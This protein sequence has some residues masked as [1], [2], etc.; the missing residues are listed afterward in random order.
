[1][2]IE[3]SKQFNNLIDIWDKAVTGNEKDS[4]YI[5]ATFY[6]KLQ[7]ESADKKAFDLYKKSAKQ[8]CTEAMYSLGVCYELGKGIR[9]NYYQAVQ[10]YIRTDHNIS[11]DLMN[12]PDPIVDSI[13]DTI[14]KY[15][16]SEE[17]AEYAD[18]IFDIEDDEDDSFEVDKKAAWCGD[19]EAQNRLG[20]RY[21]YGNGTEIDIVQAVYW[22]RESAKGGCEA[23]MLHLA[24]YYEKVRQYKKAAKW[25]RQYIELRIKWRK[26]RLG[27]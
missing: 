15:L 25:Y 20:H 13:Q 12:H 27:W 24:E 17:F 14:Y 2:K 23:G 10:W 9:R 6:G 16:D 26:E 21:F 11:E 22:Y 4:Q 1:M 18:E 3:Y 7:T 19:A 8:G 5:L